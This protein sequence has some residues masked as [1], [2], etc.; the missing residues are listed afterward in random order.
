MLKKIGNNNS[1][2]IKKGDFVTR[3]SYGHDI[4]FVVKKII[5]VNSRDIVI[6]KG[7]TLRIE[8]SAPID[9]LV[10][11]AK[12]EFQRAMAHLDYR[13]ENKIGEIKTK[14]DKRKMKF[15]QREFIYTGKILHLDGESYLSNRLKLLLSS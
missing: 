5:K 7:C 9:D 1:C 15:E 8:A 11:V 6:L 2:E 12:N 14:S 4:L 3:K 10:K 13:I